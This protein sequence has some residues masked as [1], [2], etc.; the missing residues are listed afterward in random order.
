MRREEAVTQLTTAPP[1]GST[2]APASVRLT[3][4]QAIIRFLEAQW[5]VRDGVARRAIPGVFG[6]W[7]HGNVFSIG[8]A[9]EEVATDL[10]LY[11]GKNEQSMVHAAVG[12]A[13]AACRLQ[14]LAVSA[15]IGPG[16]TNMISGAATAT[17]NRLPVLLLPADSFASRRQGP[18]LQGLEHPLE[19]DA[20]VNDAFRPVSRF[21]DRLTRPEQLLTSLPEA[22]RVLFD[23]AETG[24]VTLAVHQDVLGEAHDYP[25]IFFQPRYREIVRRPPAESELAEALRILQASERPLLIAGG[26]T[27]YSEAQTELAALSERFGIPVAETMAGKGAAG[28]RYLLG[29]LGLGGTR[30]ANRVAAEADLVISVGTRLNDIITGSQSVFR[31]PDV[32]FVGINVNSYDAHKQ[33]A[34]PV[35]ADARLSLAALVNALGQSGWS[36][37][38]S[39]QSWIESERQRWLDDLAI[40]LAPRAGERMSQAQVLRALNEFSCPDDVLVGS[41]GTVPVDILKL[42]DCADSAECHIEFGFSCMG[43]D[44]PAAMGYRLA[45]PQSGEIYAFTGDGNYLMSNPEIVTAIQE[46]WKVTVIL[47]ENGGHQSIRNSQVGVTDVMFGTEF[48]YRDPATARLT[49]S[50][51]GVDYVANARSLGCAAYEAHTLAELVDALAA[52]RTEAGSTY[53][54]AHVEPHRLMLDAEAWWDIGIAETSSRPGLIERATAHRREAEKVQRFHY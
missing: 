13:K 1:A 35:T 22:M 54:I 47:I 31:N 45:R 40:D 9:L 43:H 32:R 20:T 38:A 41:A 23:P 15:S 27:I 36:T 26:G 14:A 50:F 5:S 4:A 25:S 53:V 39:Y 21:F 8:Q 30:V 10:P 51:V 49:G 48:R 6:I 46:G 12:F 17:V 16:S 3:T 29:G 7:G 18:I 52:A 19:R 34:H 37:S 33:G 11:A 42:W 24:A 44:I 28:G 2:S